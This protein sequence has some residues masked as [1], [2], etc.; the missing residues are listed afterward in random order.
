MI[1]QSAEQGP[2]LILDVL[3]VES[4][5]EIVFVYGHHKAGKKMEQ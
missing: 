2:H 1:S 5:T 4:Y 3:N